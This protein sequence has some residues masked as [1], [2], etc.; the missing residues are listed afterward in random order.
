MDGVLIIIFFN[1]LF[2]IY[3][4]D[5]DDGYWVGKYEIKVGVKSFLSNDFFYFCYIEVLLMKVECLFCL[6]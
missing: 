2:S 1:K 6:G 4:I 3:K 5:I